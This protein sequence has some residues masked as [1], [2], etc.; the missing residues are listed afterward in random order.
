MKT[1][2]KL[3]EALATT[4]RQDS[5]QIQ[6]PMPG[7]IGGI[8]QFSEF[9]EWYSFVQKFSL[10]S[11]VSQVV[12]S[13]FERAQKLYLL[14]WVDFDLIK[15]GELVAFTALE[16]ALRDRYGMYLGKKTKKASI[17]KP[18]ERF[19]FHKLR[20]YMVE[21]DGL[22]DDKIGLC[23]RTGGNVVSLLIVRDVR[24]STDENVRTQRLSEIRNGL[25]HGDPFDSLPWSG[26]L[27]L[28]RDLIEYAYRDMIFEARAGM[29]N[30]PDNSYSL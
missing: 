2:D 4:E 19:P 12:A 27:E 6:W 5:L 23:K 8:I 11:A 25:A 17:E 10:N 20:E 14:A 13:K 1:T 28:V 16:L 29:Q 26:L 15:V 21:Q 7:N 22:S 18:P 3:L 9:S 30:M 24:G